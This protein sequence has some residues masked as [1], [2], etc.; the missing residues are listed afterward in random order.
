MIYKNSCCYYF[1]PSFQKK[2]KVKTQSCE[3]YIK[4]TQ[5]IFFFPINCKRTSYWGPH[6]WLP[7]SP[8]SVVQQRQCTVQW[9]GTVWWA[10]SVCVNF[11]AVLHSFRVAKLLSYC[12]VS[13]LGLSGNIVDTDRFLSTGPE[14]EPVMVSPSSLF[15]PLSFI[16]MQ[17]KAVFHFYSFQTFKGNLHCFEVISTGSSNLA[18]IRLTPLWAL[19]G[20]CEG[21]RSFPAWPTEKTGSE[22]NWR[23]GQGQ[24]IWAFPL[25][26]GIL[27]S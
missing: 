17:L 4:T 24:S 11:K 14:I 16:L 7:F 12:L 26:L 3:K 6:W 9:Q 18:C 23:L 5:D 1:S 13:A 19:S 27:L 2:K 20:G 21:C 8:G 25:G 22:G 15:L 10:S